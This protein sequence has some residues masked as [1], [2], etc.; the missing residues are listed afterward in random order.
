MRAFLR[1]KEQPVR[2]TGNRKN[3]EKVMKLKVG[4]ALPIAI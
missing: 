4:A 3:N 2:Q 1:D